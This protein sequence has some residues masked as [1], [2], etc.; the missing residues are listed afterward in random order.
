MGSKFGQIRPACEELAALERLKKFP[1]TYNGRIVV[2]T[3]VLSFYDSRALTR[4]LKTGVQDSHL[5]KNWSPTRKSGSPTKKSWS[6]TNLCISYIFSI[7][8]GS[9]TFE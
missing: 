5:A 1:L 8:A 2:A 7:I 4:I 6:P 9:D 3:L